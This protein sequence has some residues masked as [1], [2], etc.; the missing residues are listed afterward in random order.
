MRLTE[1]QILKIQNYLADKPVFK[2]YVFGSY[3]SGE[4][5]PDSDVD[6]LV[7]LDYKQSIGLLFVQMQLELGDLLGTEVDLVSAKGVSK[8]LLPMI[9]QN[10]ELIYA[11]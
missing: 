5:R 10:R 3:A 4:A 7:E 11:R 6:L 8:R 1:E 9:E 2:A